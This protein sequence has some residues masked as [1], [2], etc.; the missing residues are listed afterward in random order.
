MADRSNPLAKLTSKD[1]VFVDVSPKVVKPKVVREGYSVP[2]P[3]FDVKKTDF[4]LEQLAVITPKQ[5]PR[6]VSQSIPAGTRVT[7]G[8]VIDLVLAPSQA[9]PFDIMTDVHADLRNKPLTFLTETVL[10]NPKA[11]QILLTH[12]RPE[13]VPADERSFLKAQFEAQDMTVTDDE[14]ERGFNR[15]WEAARG[16]LAF[17]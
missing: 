17:K 6:V 4:V 2:T 1:F 12:E 16:A 13:D 10:D 5:S 15:A 7:P 8:T 11:R 3:V 14:G 9:I